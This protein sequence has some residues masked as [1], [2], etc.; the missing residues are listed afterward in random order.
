MGRL[1]D[2][3]AIV[4]DPVEA[5]FYGGNGGVLVVDITAGAERFFV[6]NSSNEITE[7]SGGSRKTL[8]TAVVSISA[9]GTV[10]AAVTAKR[11][12]IY[13]VK[14]VCSADLSIKFRDGAS[15]DLEGSQDFLANGGVAEAVTP[16]EFLFATTAGNRLDLVISGTGTVSGRISYWDD[17]AT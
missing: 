5:D 7:L 16:P 8:K 9:T 13:A 6:L 17:D 4:G 11:L 2:V 3:R 1:S 12:K 14:L 10:I 15:T